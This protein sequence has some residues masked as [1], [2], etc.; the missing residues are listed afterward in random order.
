MGPFDAQKAEIDRVCMRIHGIS[1][2]WCVY[3]SIM[4]VS[5]ALWPWVFCSRAFIPPCHTTVHIV[6]ITEACSPAIIPE[7]SVFH[8]MPTCCVIV[9]H[10]YALP[11]YQERNVHQIYLR[12][13]EGHCLNTFQAF[14]AFNLKTYPSVSA[15]NDSVT[16]IHMNM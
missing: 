11:L 13:H 5:A 9:T 7:L 6:T 15:R 4:Y 1:C 10:L 8:C 12:E 2:T 3:V 16:T 14:L